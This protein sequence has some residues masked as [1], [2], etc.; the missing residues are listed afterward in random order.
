MKKYKYNKG[1]LPFAYDA[2]CFHK[3]P[4][5]LYVFCAEAS[6]RMLLPHRML[7]MG[8][9]VVI[10]RRRGHLAEAI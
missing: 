8:D 5:L 2:S 9:I 3:T 10:E 4:A 6:Q 7:P 1:F